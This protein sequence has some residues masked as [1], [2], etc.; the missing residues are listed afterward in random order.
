MEQLI[1]FIVGEITLQLTVTCE[2]L[3]IFLKEGK[4]LV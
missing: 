3:N 4:L 2:E 1:Y